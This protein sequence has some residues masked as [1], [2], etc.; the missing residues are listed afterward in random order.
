MSMPSATCARR[1]AATTPPVGRFQTQPVAAGRHLLG[2]RSR[3]FI[4]QP[5]AADAV[6]L[7]EWDDLAK[8]ENKATPPLAHFLARAGAAPSPPQGLRLPP[9]T[10]LT[11]PVLCAVLFGALLHAGWNALVKSSTDKALDMAV[12]HLIGSVLAC[13]W[14]CWWAAARRPGRTSALRC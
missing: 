2:R 10:L 11:W 6:K 3:R 5:G 9:E 14:C 8:D 13:P 7:R 4:A 12:I 1:G